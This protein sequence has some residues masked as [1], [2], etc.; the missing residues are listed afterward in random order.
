MAGYIITGNIDE[1]CAKLKNTLQASDARFNAGLKAAFKTSERPVAK[2]ISPPPSMA[3]RPSEAPR[4]ASAAGPQPLRAADAE[5]RA[6]FGSG[7]SLSLTRR[8]DG[9]GNM[10]SRLR[11][12]LRSTER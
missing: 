3:P 8:T 11:N 2:P 12:S 5:A 6:G 1:A 4:Q 10:R 9:G 7:A